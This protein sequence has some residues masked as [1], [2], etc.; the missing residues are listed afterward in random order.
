M[1]KYTL[2]QSDSGIL[3]PSTNLDELDLSARS[4]QSI[5]I[6]N[7]CIPENALG[8][9]YSQLFFNWQYL[10]NEWISNFHFLN[11]LNINER[12]KRRLFICNRFIKACILFCCI[13]ISC[14]FIAFRFTISC[15]LTLFEN[16]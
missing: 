5:L 6:Q 13:V 7:L 8:Q 3:E 15:F 9:S 2:A 4:N 10:L 11:V 1:T 12:N 16:I 14:S